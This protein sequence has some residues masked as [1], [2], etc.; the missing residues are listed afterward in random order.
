[1]YHMEIYYCTIKLLDV[2]GYE[3]KEKIFFPFAETTYGILE[4]FRYNFAEYIE[5]W[6]EPSNLENSY[7]RNA[8]DIV[9]I[10]K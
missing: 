7:V 4:Q 5:K 6:K 9:T 10:M 1:M 3:M 8:N 2:W